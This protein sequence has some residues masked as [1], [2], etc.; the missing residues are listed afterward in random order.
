MAAHHA[1]KNVRCLAPIPSVT[2]T[3]RLCAPTAASLV[4]GRARTKKIASCPVVLHVLDYLA[5]S[6]ARRR[7]DVAINALL[8]VANNV[9]QPYTA[10][11]ARVTQTL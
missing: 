5:I 1:R 9:R 2:S 6:A 7:F 8:S 11:S 3:V 4:L 10:S